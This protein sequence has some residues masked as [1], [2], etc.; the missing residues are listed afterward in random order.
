MATV[1]EADAKHRAALLAKIGAAQSV[2][3]MMVTPGAVLLRRLVD[4]K[5]A[6]DNHRWLSLDKAEAALLWEKARGYEEFFNLAKQVMLEGENAKRQLD[7][8]S[9]EQSQ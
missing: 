8:A 5:C 7:A 1:D 6:R 9:P 3:D 4:E 2:R